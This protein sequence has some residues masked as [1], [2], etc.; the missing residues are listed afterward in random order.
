[1]DD[2]RLPK[3]IALDRLE[4][5]KQLLAGF[6]SLRRDIDSNGAMAGMDS[7][8][9]RAFD[10][11]AS[12]T[13]RRALDLTKEDLKS[14]DRYQK[15]EQFLLARRLVEAGVGCVTLTVGGFGWDTHDQNFAKLR[16]L[17]PDVDRG[18]SN[19]IQD[20][21]DRGLDQDVVTVMWGEF[22]RTPKVQSDNAGRGHWS[23]AMSVLVA[24]G[25]LKMGQMV[26]ATT[27]RA[28]VP[29]D[30]PYYVPHVLATAY[31]AMGID[32]SMTIPHP[33]GRPMYILDERDPVSEL[34]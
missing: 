18:L 2:L 5:R 24:G 13:V 31:R 15:I 16:K 19:L 26:G 33:S 21:H 20:L 8:A 11:V 28:E 25:G 27:A 12:G 9:R 23:P 30:R 6:D 4:D 34:L 29:K 17:L 22:G 7:F 14:R 32:P 10:M 1:M 3:D